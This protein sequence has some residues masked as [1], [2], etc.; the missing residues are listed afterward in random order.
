VGRYSGFVGSQGQGS[1]FLRKG[2][3]A[4]KE[5]ITLHKWYP[6]VYPS[7]RDIKVEAAERRAERLEN[8]Y[9]LEVEAQKMRK[10]VEEF[11][12]EL[13]NKRARQATVELEIFSNKRHFDK[14][15]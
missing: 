10:K 4:G 3:G 1:V 6:F 8:E 13:Y 9:R 5:M 12:L 2:G 11:D 14:F 15:V 7:P